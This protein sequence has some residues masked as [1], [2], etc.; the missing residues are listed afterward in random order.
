MSP[1]PRVVVVGAGAA[2][3]SAAYRLV[4]RGLRPTLVEAEERIGGRLETVRRDG[5]TADLGAQVLYSSYRATLGLCRELGLGRRLVRLR[6]SARILRKRRLCSQ[7]E[8]LD[9]W[10]K[11]LSIAALQLSLRLGRHRPPSRR[12]EK[13][14]ELDAIDFESYV[15]S[16]FGPELL[17]DLFEPFVA[18]LVHERSRRISAACGLTY[19]G[20]AAGR[21]YALRGGM[22]ELT[23]RLASHL[24]DVRLG[25]PA[26]EVLIEDGEVRGVRLAGADRVLK[27]DRVVL[28]VPAHAASRL[29]PALPAA[30]REELDAVPYS[31]S[32][33]VVLGLPRPATRS[34]YAVVSPEG[35]HGRA[36]C[37]LEDAA[38]GGSSVPPGRGL[39]HC[40]L[41]GSQAEWAMQQSDETLV[42]TVLAELHDVLPGAPRSCELA[43]VRRWT[44]SVCLWGAHHAAAVESLLARVRSVRGLY[45]AGDFLEIPSVE[46][47][48]SSGLE[49]AERL[50]ADVASSGRIAADC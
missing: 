8:L 15:R 30:A 27:C 50:L 49:A 39:L 31:A 28:A 32:V 38:R 13:W 11:R 2:G 22:A 10:P 44:D 33:H 47:A 21:T 34:L 24:P 48:V 41:T 45:L 37:L 17:A 36:S 26:G 19:V 20:W 35:E 16:R 6:A 5:F 29:A 42:E 3:L 7:L 25:Q 46:G 9:S 40:F 12:A 4:R 18:A 43:E 14:R 23:G 1:A